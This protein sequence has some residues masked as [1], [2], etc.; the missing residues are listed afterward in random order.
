MPPALGV[1]SLNHWTA[2]EVP[3]IW[4]FT[5]KSLLTTALEG[6]MGFWWAELGKEGEVGRKE[7]TFHLRNEGVKT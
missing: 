3:I 7:Q 4:F 1:L 2:R 5:K 6:W